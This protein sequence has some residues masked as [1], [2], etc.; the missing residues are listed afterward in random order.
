ML[1]CLDPVHGSQSGAL[2]VL[3]VDKFL[4]T[5]HLAVARLCDSI[6]CRRV[7]RLLAENTEVRR[8]TPRNLNSLFSLLDLWEILYLFIADSWF[9]C[10]YTIA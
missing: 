4:C 5:P 9:I 10:K 8:G 2:L 7:E 1:E 6:A 3:L